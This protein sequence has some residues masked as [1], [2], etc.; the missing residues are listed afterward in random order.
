M[1]SCRWSTCSQ[2]SS[3]AHG[4]L[5]STDTIQKYKQNNLSKLGG[6]NEAL[7]GQLSDS[8]GKIQSLL[9]SLSSTKEFN[10]NLQSQM[11]GILIY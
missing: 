1:A 7:V 8:Q 3:A 2:N 11:R 4:V 9:D 6:Q 5:I 10:Q